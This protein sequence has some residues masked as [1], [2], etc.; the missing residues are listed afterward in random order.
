MYTLCFAIQ[1]LMVTALMSRG[2][3]RC[4]WEER[5]QNTPTGVSPFADGKQAIEH[6]AGVVQAQQYRPAHKT[7]ISCSRKAGQ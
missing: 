3:V 6:G 2:D 1:E 5:Q 7:H 4:A